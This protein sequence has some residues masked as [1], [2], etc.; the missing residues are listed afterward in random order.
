MSQ[1][2]IPLPITDENAVCDRF[3]NPLNV[4]THVLFPAGEDGGMAS[5]VI[6]GYENHYFQI[7]RMH[8]RWTNGVLQPAV[9]ELS[10]LAKYHGL[11]NQEPLMDPQAIID[12]N[13]AYV[14]VLDFSPSETKKGSRKYAVYL[15]A[16]ETLP[17]STPF[18]EMFVVVTTIM[19]STTDEL[20]M[21]DRH[22]RLQN[23]YRVVGRLCSSRSRFS[24]SNSYAGVQITG[25]KHNWNVFKRD[26]T[27][28]Q[29]MRHSEV[30]N[31]YVPQSQY[32]LSKRNMQD[33]G[34]I[35]HLDTVFTVEEYN[36]LDI[37]ELSKVEIL[38]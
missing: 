36:N 2:F 27:D 25:M 13:A 7:G 10:H 9:A 15:V 24:S 19:G 34:L 5:G 29:H 16:D 20:D 18:R 30:H 1:P 28:W 17:N 26:Y 3:G 35:Q 21:L 8:A 22:L 32:Q 38:Q 33:I 23:G 31:H 11:I 6:C 14:P 37:E 4:G 12:Q